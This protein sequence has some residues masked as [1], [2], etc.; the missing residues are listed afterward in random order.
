[1]SL[2]NNSNKNFTLDNI[3]IETFLTNI[4]DW[5]PSVDRATDKKTLLIFHQFIEEAAQNKAK[6]Q[7]FDIEQT[8]RIYE[9][10]SKKKQAYYSQYNIFQRIL[11]IIGDLFHISSKYAVIKKINK[12]IEQILSPYK[13][14][15]ETLY[16][17]FKNDSIKLE[18]LTG[19]SRNKVALFYRL[20]K[21]NLPRAT[22]H[23]EFFD[24]AKKGDIGKLFFF[25]N[26]YEIDVNTRNPE[27]MTPLALACEAGQQEIVKLLLK[28]KDLHINFDD[29][30]GRTPLALACQAGHEEIVKLLI[31]QKLL[32]VN[33]RDNQNRTPLTLACQAGHEE[34]VKL[35]LKNKDVNV[36][37]E[38][39]R[40]TTPFVQA[41]V[42]QNHTIFELLLEH[43]DVDVNSLNSQA[44]RGLIPTFPILAIAA[45]NGHLKHVEALLKF[46]NSHSFLNQT[47]EEY[48]AFE[49]AIRKN[50]REIIEA[51]INNGKVNL[52]AKG[53][54]GNPPLVVAVK[55]NLPIIVNLLLKTGKINLFCTDTE[56]QRV[57]DWA[58]QKKYWSI[59]CQ[60]KIAGNSTSLSDIQKG[61]IL[62]CL[63]EKNTQ[64][65]LPLLFEP[66]ITLNKK[67]SHKAADSII[68]CLQSLNIKDKN[69]N[70]ILDSLIAIASKLAIDFPG[71]SISIV[72]K[73]K[74]LSIKNGDPLNKFDEIQEEILQKLFTYKLEYDEFSALLKWKIIDLDQLLAK[75]TEDQ[76]AMIYRD[77]YK[78]NKSHWKE[79][80]NTKG[81]VVPPLAK[82]IPDDEYKKL[83]TIFDSTN[84]KD[85]SKPDYVDSENLIYDRVKYAV[86]TLK[87]DI[88]NLVN[89]VENREPIL[90]APSKEKT[91]IAFQEWYNTL[92]TQLNHITLS[93]QKLKS[94][95]ERFAH[96]FR[97]AVEARTCA[98]GKQEAIVQIYELLMG[99]TSKEGMNVKEIVLEMLYKQREGI[100]DEIVL[101][102]IKTTDSH[103][104][105][106]A[107]E[108][109][110]PSIGLPSTQPAGY[111]DPFLPDYFK[112]PDRVTAVINLA[113]QRI[114]SLLLNHCHVMV[115]KLLE[116]QIVREKFIGWFNSKHSQEAEYDTANYIDFHYGL[117]IYFIKRSALIELL[118]G[119]NVIHNV[120]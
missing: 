96:L 68:E 12:V 4:Q 94:Q 1:M 43:E 61:S 64:L 100:L 113:T 48:T 119:I 39:Y 117:N 49:W 14:S 51:F 82:G 52:N 111:I 15:K 71:V 34:I 66:A 9:D 40:G 31:E 53:S 47:H 46:E 56:G 116:N 32:N 101:K 65:Q 44:R 6:N 11:Y 42:N 35:L 112:D 70:E 57:F 120:F 38:D 83:L 85:K 67:N 24:A 27:G 75:A 90:A 93:L 2:N 105:N 86:T 98:T 23:N 114:E 30:K 18:V 69:F 17:R 108:I 88:M 102:D 95:S 80:I 33:A 76:V 58:I 109:I 13:Q 84:F 36:N 50:H 104:I 26:T 20:F 73:I 103:Y 59:V 106:G 7:E 63:M 92:Q 79:K 62:N 118:K 10:L 97:L 89:I 54:F 60:L 77:R 87:I 25:M 19:E 110:G 29:H 78:I 72:D 5:T 8:T 91:P 45:K 37:V 16:D 107:R 74:A 99:V 41:C 3:K 115:N 21:G 22:S 81:V 28:N 55:F